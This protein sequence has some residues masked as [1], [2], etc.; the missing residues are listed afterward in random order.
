MPRSVYHQS[1]GN[2]IQLA[3]IPLQPL[4]LEFAYY[5]GVDND[6]N[7]FASRVLK[8]VV[9]A[10]FAAILLLWLWA[11]IFDFAPLPI[12]ILGFLILLAWRVV[13]SQLDTM[14]GLICCAIAGAWIYCLVP[15]P[16]ALDVFV[17]LA[18]TTHLAREIVRHFTF[19]AT[20]APTDL[21]TAWTIRENTC[22]QTVVSGL[23]M[24]PLAMGII[25]PSAM[26]TMLL[27]GGVAWAGLF[28]AYV[29]QPRDYAENF[30]N[31]IQAWCSYN[32][33]DTR[34][35]GIIISPS[36]TCKQ[37]LGLLFGI[38]LLNASVIFKI[39]L[40]PLFGG[41]DI[42]SESL[43]GIGGIG[44][45]FL[46]LLLAVLV[47][48]IAAV[49]PLSLLATA[50]CVVG[51]PVFGRYS[52]PEP[53]Y[54]PASEWK[55]I[56][57]RIRRS[58]NQIEANSFYQG[59]VSYDQSPL[60]VPQEVYKEHAHFLGDTGSGKTSRGLA[61]LIEQILSTGKA[62]V[63]VLD[64]KG[65]SQELLQTMK[66]GIATARDLYGI[67]IPIRYFSLREDQS[68]FGFN[69]FLLPC[70]TELND[71]QKTDILCGALG[72]NYGSEYGEGYFSSANA[73][74]LFATVRNFPEV[75]SFDDLADKIS[76]VVARPKAHGIDDKSRDA[77]NHV[78]MIVT[79]LATIAALNIHDKSTPSDEVRKH[80]I[81]PSRLFSNP[82]AHYYSLS[83]T[84]GPGSSPEVGRLA[85]YMLMMASTL[86]K[87][88]FPVYLVIDEFQ[89]MA[90]RNL[91]YLLQLARSMGVSVIL[92]NQSM[93]D[94]ERYNL[95]P[96]LETNCRYR[97]WFSV[98][99]WEDQDR[100]SRHSG[101]TV[102]MLNG[103]SISTSSNSKGTTSST[104]FSNNEFVGP[105]LTHNDIKLVSDDDRK[106]IVL[107]N[108]GAGYAQYGGMPVIV[109]CDFHISAEEYE[110]RKESAWPSGDVGT[111]VATNWNRPASKTSR[112]GRSASSSPLITQETID[113][114]EARVNRSQSVVDQ[115]SR[116]SQRR[117]PSRGWPMHLPPTL[118]NA[119]SVRIR[120]N[121]N[122]MGPANGRTSYVP[123]L[124]PRNTRPR[125][126]THL[127]ASRHVTKT[128]SPRLGLHVPFSKPD[129]RFD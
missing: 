118:L 13:E 90:S 107:I 127:S 125:R 8:D 37:R 73:S 41:I 25:V 24:L 123:K 121:R 5:R 70:W 10:S 22:W 91:D 49:L 96:V 89:R 57:D 18:G 108:R 6:D 30:W 99:G 102:D 88:E 117:Q 56:T 50:T 40:L 105:R 63:M 1:P 43:F 60:L 92:A 4:E 31:S 15:L 85:T 36:G 59:R 54:V 116:N 35:A 47:S 115:R 113:T 101:E 76:Y 104:S 33:R 62:S 9:I 20:V 106:S 32:R 75:K 124:D 129:C 111:F 80:C 51:T 21:Q 81:D 12:I 120:S 52:I 112:R 78:K 14:P 3:K 39:L 44:E 61:P 48:G 100:L 67:D 65:D 34:I 38:V 17:A 27:L 19:L 11:R 86:T 98:S 28:A 45:L 58:S 53:S 7:E 77:G 55:A 26:P 46:H 103:K 72:L 126:N 122:L 93:Q 128:D 68:T 66:C 87:R 69:P 2:P 97:Q 71:L 83:A 82:E 42:G 109:D 29:S 16:H 64:L 84:L 95:I 94:L 119:I 23:V 114:A 79:R 74:V 110:K